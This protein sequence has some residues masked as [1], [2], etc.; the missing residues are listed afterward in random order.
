MLTTTLLY[1]VIFAVFVLALSFKDG[2]SDAG[3][4]WLRSLALRHV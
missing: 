3:C 4:P 1:A 2:A